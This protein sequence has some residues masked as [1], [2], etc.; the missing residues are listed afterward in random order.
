LHHPVAPGLW[1]TRADPE[2]AAAFLVRRRP[3]KRIATMA[4]LS[5]TVASLRV[6]GDDLD[7]DA[8]ERAGSP[9]AG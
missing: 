5:K 2:G 1:R 8:A 9:Q 3:E 6:I 7:P 4:E